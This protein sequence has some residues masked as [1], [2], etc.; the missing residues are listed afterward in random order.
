MSIT[1]ITPT[2]DQ[3]IGMR[4]LEK[5]MA[6]QTVQPDEWIVADDGEVPARLALG[7]K[8]IVGD[9]LMMGRNPSPIISWP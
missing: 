9:E 7:Q 4:L 3:P 6:R 5:Y 2:A 8:H 1:V